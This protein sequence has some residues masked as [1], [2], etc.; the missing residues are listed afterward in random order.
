VSL[1]IISIMMKTT[2]FKFAFCS[3]IAFTEVFGVNYTISNGSDSDGAFINDFEFDF[4]SSEDESN[5]N[6]DELNASFIESDSEDTVEE[7]RNL[8]IDDSSSDDL[9]NTSFFLTPCQSVKFDE[10]NKKI[11]KN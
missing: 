4:T 11:L 1:S 3:A 10:G 6:E 8:V 9:M 2:F 7:K 5:N